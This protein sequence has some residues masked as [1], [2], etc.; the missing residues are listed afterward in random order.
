MLNE[1]IERYPELEIC[2][3]DIEKAK[4]AIIECYN[5]GGKLLLCVSA[6]LQTDMEAAFVRTRPRGGFAFIHKPRRTERHTFQP[7][8]NERFQH[9]YRQPFCVD[10]RNVV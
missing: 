3:E 4:E 2:V 5:K 8:S 9:D 1:L 6:R 10:V 7:E